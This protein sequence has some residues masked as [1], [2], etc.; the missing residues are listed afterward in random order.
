[1]TDPIA[2]MLTRIRN[3]SRVGKREVFV[4]FSKLKL[5]IVKILKQEGFI[6]GYEEI[7][8]ESADH[9]FGGIMITLKYDERKPAMSSL[10]RVSTPGRR[11]YAGKEDLPRVLNGFGVAIVS[12]SQGIMTAR[13]AQKLGLGG[14]VLCEIY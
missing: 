9:R 5:A 1:M 13:A 11:V 4:P 12:N 2:D 8:S 14:E 7:K 10:K 6:E 3:A